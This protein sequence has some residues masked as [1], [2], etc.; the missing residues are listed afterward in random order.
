VSSDYGL[1]N[2]IVMY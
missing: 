2:T 1:P